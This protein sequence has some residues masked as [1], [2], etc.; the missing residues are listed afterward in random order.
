MVGAILHD[1]SIL[2]EITAYSSVTA[3][4]GSET[5]PSVCNALCNTLDGFYCQSFHLTSYIAY[6]WYTVIRLNQAR[7]HSLG[8]FSSGSFS[9]K[10]IC[11]LYKLIHFYY[12]KFVW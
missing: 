5:Y 1:L 12:I 8:K 4:G 2:Y 3:Y 7:L 9:K 11:E 10:N 6:A